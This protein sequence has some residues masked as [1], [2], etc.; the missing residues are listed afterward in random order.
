MELSSTLDQHIAVFGESGSGKT[1]LLT[2][3]YGASRQPNAVATMGYKVKAEDF[4]LGT[5][6]YQSFLGMR[7]DSKLPMANRFQGV[8]HSFVVTPEHLP[9]G[10]GKKA[11][12]THGFS[13]LRLFWHDYPGEWFESSASSE[14]ERK[15]RLETFQELLT[16][17]VALLLVD[18]QKLKNNSGEEDRYLK[19]L[20]DNFKRGI[21]EVEEGLVDAGPLTTF[22]RVWVLALSKADILPELDVHGFRDLLFKKAGPELTELRATISRIVAFPDAFALGEEFLLL[23]S[24]KFTPGQIDVTDR[25]GV[26][27]ILP[28]A[29]MLP[30]ERLAQWRSEDKLSDGA[31]RQLVGEGLLLAKT[32]VD[33]H[34]QTAI[35]FLMDLV[36]KKFK[37]AAIV[38]RPALERALEELRHQMDKSLDEKR[39]AHQ[40]ARDSGDVIRSIVTN[41]QILL[42]EAEASDVLL[43]GDR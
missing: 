30:L 32:L 42:A 1:V 19:A 15:R 9:G 37:P 38:L 34:G 2:S 14:E 21:E 12:N 40:E 26:D 17:D 28:I 4:S 6:L 31:F 41:F 18:A 35:N 22:P 24:A 10:G 5:L 16:S 7:D 25:V 43:R 20:F 8:N 36:P 39:L 33:K 29:E 23:S 3:W 27:L 11:D 13:S